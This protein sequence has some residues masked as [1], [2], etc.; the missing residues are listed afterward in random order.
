MSRQNEIDRFLKYYA[1]IYKSNPDLTTNRDLFY[2]ALMSYDCS[3]DFRR[4]TKTMF[5]TWQQRYNQSNLHTFI[6]SLQ[7][8]FLQIWSKE[9]G[10]R[11]PYDYK[12][13]LNLPYQ[14]IEEGVIKIFDFLSSNN[15]ETRSK[16]ADIRRSDEIVLRLTKKEDAIKVINYL[17]NEPYFQKYSSKTNPF[18]PRYGV[19]GA[20]YDDLESYNCVISDL[21]SQYYTTKIKTKTLDKVSLVDFSTFVQK[22]YHG[23]FH[24]HSQMHQYF[25]QPELQDYTRHPN[26]E[27]QILNH[28]NI[29]NLIIKSLKGN[30]LI[31]NFITML[32]TCRDEKK[33]QIELADLSDIY[34]NKDRNLNTPRISKEQKTLDDYINLAI[35]MYGLKWATKYLKSYINGNLNSI[36][37]EKGFRSLFRQY[38]SPN[39]VLEIADYDIENYMVEV[40]LKSQQSKY[41]LFQRACQATYQKYGLSQLVKAIS[42]SL[43]GKFSYMTESSKEKLRTKLNEQC[44]AVDVRNICDCLLL[45]NSESPENKNEVIAL[46]TILINQ[47]DPKQ[48]I[49]Y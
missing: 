24:D 8:R 33:A 26:K 40:Y 35:S 25:D 14:N 1:T 41:N 12:L 23:I 21:L 44:T 20:A 9:N 45:Q 5:P 47:K 38:L 37:R 4:T 3:K 39:Q 42:E 36:T 22:T 30:L 43:D 48:E 2:N 49:T 46:A 18:I 28:K 27:S 29:M 13:Y 10:T 31:E 6:S 34:L 15:I 32:E 7:P 17:N 19:V 16:V 11:L